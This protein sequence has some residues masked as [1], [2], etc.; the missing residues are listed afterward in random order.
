MEIAQEACLLP[1]ILLGF[2]FSFFSLS[3]KLI[4]LHT[5]NRKCVE[6]ILSLLFWYVSFK[7]HIRSDIYGC[8]QV[9]KKA[10]TFD[11]LQVLT[12]IVQAVL[13]FVSEYFSKQSYLI[14][15]V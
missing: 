8:K 5:S 7:H 2:F 6:A 1:V 3:I 12:N 15:Q 11:Q 4:I 9:E 10:G 14:I 13:T